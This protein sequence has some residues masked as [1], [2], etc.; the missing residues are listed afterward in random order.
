MLA[1]GGSANP[2]LTQGLTYWVV[3]GLGE[4]GKVVTFVALQQSKISP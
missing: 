1:H 4:L 3:L 2:G